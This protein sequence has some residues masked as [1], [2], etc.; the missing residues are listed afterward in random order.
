MC[1]LLK[2]S[3]YCRVCILAHRNGQNNFRLPEKMIYSQT[4]S[5]LKC[6]GV[7]CRI[8]YTVFD[9]PPVSLLNLFDYINAYWRCWWAI[10][11]QYV[12]RQPEKYS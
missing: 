7:S 9:T 10:Y 5:K 12:F 2:K 4:T 6:V 8:V 3:I 11:V 1:F